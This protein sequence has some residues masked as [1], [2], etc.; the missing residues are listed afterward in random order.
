MEPFT[1]LYCPLNDE[2]LVMDDEQIEEAITENKCP[3]C[4]E[5]GVIK[6]LVSV[7]P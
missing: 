4:A 3:N 2:L 6:V 5:E 1:A 7:A